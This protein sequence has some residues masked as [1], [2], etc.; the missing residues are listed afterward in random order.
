MLR[1][2]SFRIGSAS[3]SERPDVEISGEARDVVFRGATRTT[4]LHSN[5]LALSIELPAADAPRAGQ[6][7]TVHI[8][9]GE[10]WALPAAG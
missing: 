4:N 3:G 7:V 8:P 2:T 10:A 6:T 1:P 9:A 5:G